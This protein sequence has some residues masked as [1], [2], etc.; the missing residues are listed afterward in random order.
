VHISVK[1]WIEGER[2]SREKSP[3]AGRINPDGLPVVTK[4][5]ERFVA[6]AVRPYKQEPG[7]AFAPPGLE[8][9]SSGVYG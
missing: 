9:I 1:C 3:L 5:I 4:T 8:S 7:E 6:R 2:A